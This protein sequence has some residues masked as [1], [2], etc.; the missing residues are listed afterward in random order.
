MKKSDDLSRRE[1]IQLMVGAGVA[2]GLPI[3]IPPELIAQQ[4]Q[5]AYEASHFA[6]EQTEQ[7]L[8]TLSP[9]AQTD[10]AFLKKFAPI[11]IHG[12]RYHQGEV[13][14]GQSTSLNDSSWEKIDSNPNPPPSERFVHHAYWLRKWVDV[15]KSIDGYD[16][17]GDTV[18]V[19]ILIHSWG[20]EGAA[21]YVNGERMFLV[22]RSDPLVFKKKPGDRFLI[23]IHVGKAFHGAGFPDAFMVADYS[24]RRPNP[25][26]LYIESVVA[27]LLIPRLSSNPKADAKILER[28]VA[29]IDQQA[30]QAGDQSRFDRSLKAAQQSLEPLRPMLRKATFEEVG[31]TH[32][33]AAWLWTW[34]ETV[35]IVR[36]T[37]GTALDL[38]KEFPTYTYAQSAMQYNAW[39]A[40]KYPELNAGIKRRIEEGRWTLVGGMW[41]EPDLNMPGGESQVRQLLI[42]ER[43]LERLYGKTTRVG[44]NPDTFGYNWQLPQIYKRSGLDYFMTHKMELNETNPLPFKLFWWT[45]PDGSK[46]LVYFPHEIS[47][48]DL[49]PVRLAND[50]VRARELAPGMLEM[51]DIY[52]VGD[53]GGGPT[54]YVLNQGVHWMEPGKVVPKMRF[55][56]PETYLSAAE[57][58]V[59]SDSP[60]WNYEAMAKGVEPLPR[61]PA[62]KMTIPTW[63]D[64]LYFEHHRG[65]YTTQAKHKRNMRESEVWMLNAEKYSSLAWLDGSPYP[66]S[67]LTS[68]WEKVLFNQFH[69]LAAGSGIAA[70]YKDAQRQYA[71][72][73]CATDAI[74]AKSLDAIQARIHTGKEGQVPILVFNPLGWSRS[75]LVEF[76]VEMPTASGDDLSV[77]DRNG[78]VLPSKV[79][80]R[81]SNANTYHL[82][83]KVKDVPS[84]GYTVLY[85]LPGRRPFKSDLKASGLTLENSHLRVT[86]DPKT[87]YITSLYNKA[88]QFETLAADSYGNQL[89]AFHDLPLVDDAWDIDPGTLDHPMLLMDLDSVELVETGPMRA[90]IRAKRSWSQSKFV[91]D[92]ILYTDSDEVEVSNHVDWHE[93]HVLLKTAFP[94]AVKNRMATYEIPYGSIERPTTRNN[95]WENAKFEVPALRWADLSDGQHGFSLINDSKYGY[96]CKGSLLRLSLL[97]SPVDPDP[98]ADRGPQHCRYLLYPH[99]GDWK[100]ALTIRRGYN[101]NCKLTAMQVASH[102]GEMQPEHSFFSLSNDAVVLSA[103]KK[104]EDED[105]LILRFYEWAGKSGEVKI[106]L[107][108]GAKSA[109]LTNLM[110]KPEGAP[111]VISSSSEVTVP[112]SPYAIQTLRV[113]YSLEKA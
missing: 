25:R 44:W 3:V 100:Q 87:G 78:N 106:Q 86:V 23:A 10:I 99:Q 67:E 46:I 6:P 93:T 92:I 49:N 34:T 22:D 91:Q 98:N 104:A 62:G 84:C 88:T 95:S 7:A 53:H 96:D 102:Q 58:K 40:E 82:L 65:T 12:W 43:T 94:L 4:N 13:K 39:I 15:P 69:D 55:T 8:G 73:R 50:L 76:T 61:P 37:F 59:S 27:A 90:V 77:T 48:Q 9:Q 72:V 89:Q 97:R 113:D 1:A 11:E 2:G 64:E 79:L 36:R 54:R 19:S 42:G 110:E 60:V 51:M 41:V 80:S 70:I 38:M 108:P 74:S 52:G 56:T 63:N 14:S 30:L 103:V 24:G 26:D 45:S 17:G 5:R 112:V 71:Q 47:S 83:V 105:G 57:A 66:A 35:T 101:F 107:P 21:I 32:I 68:A 109:T 16:L 31:N 20:G 85:A 29:E 75:G 18:T 28:A 111:L 81:D 33:D